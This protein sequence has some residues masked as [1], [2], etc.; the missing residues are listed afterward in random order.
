MKR[1][2]LFIL[3][4]AIGLSWA[5]GCAVC[6]ATLF[7]L[8]RLGLPIGVAIPVALGIAGLAAALAVRLIWKSRRHSPPSLDDSR[9]RSYGFAGM[10]T[11]RTR[12][13]AVPSPAHPSC[14]R[15]V[16]VL[17]LLPAVG[18]PAL[19]AV[20]CGVAAWTAWQ[21]PFAAWDAWSIWAF[22][23][24]AFAGGGLPLSYFHDQQTLFTHP[25]YPLNLPLVE[26]VLLR[27]G[28]P[29]GDH[30]A[31]L[32]GPVSFLALLLLFYTGL[33]RLYGAGRAAWAVAALAL[34]P[35]LASQAA[36]GDADV[37]LALY[38][39]GAALYLAL[40]WRRR[41]SADALLCA[42]LAGGAAWTKK[43]GLPVALLLIAAFTTGEVWP[44]TVGALW[45]RLRQVAAVWALALALPLPWLLFNWRTH[46][47][48]RDFLPLTPGTLL[49][50]L[51]RLPEIARFFGLLMLSF[52]HWSLLWVVL[53]AV[54]VLRRRNLTGRG[55]ALL[56][57]LALQLAVYAL[58]FVFSDWQPY[59]DHIRTSLD[60]LL[61]QA[62]PL[63]VLVLSEVACAGK[64]EP[65]AAHEPP[66]E[67][68]L[69]G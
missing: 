53:A 44:G 11:R 17:S 59:T 41:E 66:A 35:A 9:P 21:A 57:L 1:A 68:P 31:A 30:L 12:T 36:G 42:L 6:S 15:Q 22:K 46:P 13:S 33:A 24:H 52:Q 29:A 62:V 47:I 48:G 37:P 40:W 19:I 38:A 43:E 61:V 56:V 3:Y 51:D 49:A 28:G 25:D 7:L 5:L 55:G 4:E 26:A 45:P 16:R 2:R 69:A 20:V 10:R 32:P 27:L 34:V 39:G 50:H 67:L 54:L 58:A 8:W 65:A 23:A 63:A 14:A 18:A 64:Q 60:R